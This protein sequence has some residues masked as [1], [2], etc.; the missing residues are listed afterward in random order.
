MTED[1]HRPLALRG[2]VRSGSPRSNLP[3]PADWQSQPGV[4]WVYVLE[5]KATGKRYV[6]Q[7]NDLRSRVR[8]HNE[9]A[10]NRSLFTG[11]DAGPWI[12]IHSERCASRAAAL[13][14][15]RFLKGG[16][17]REWLRAR[18]AGGTSPPQAD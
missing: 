3:R 4:F 5:S 10:T 6:G 16:Q 2:T 7:T 8:Q 11:R 14:R 18:L 13:A 1:L 17:G 15:E 9:P 12:L